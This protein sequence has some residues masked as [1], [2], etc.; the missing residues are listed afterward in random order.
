MDERVRDVPA[1]DAKAAGFKVY[2]VTDASGD[3]SL[4]IADHAR[5]IC[6][7]WDCADLDQCRPR[8]C[9]PAPPPRLAEQR[10]SIDIRENDG[11]ASLC[12]ALCRGEPHAG[13]RASN[14]GDLSLE[15]V[16][17][18]HDR[19]SLLIYAFRNQPVTE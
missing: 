14:E 1:L 8:L 11:R 3:P 15:I 5:K 6:A 12:K 2:A 10:L 17:R 4:R 13:A 9:W 16:S 19:F 18:I 7:G